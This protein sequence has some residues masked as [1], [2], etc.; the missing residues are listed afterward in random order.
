MSVSKA[1]RAALLLLA[2]VAL[3]ACVPT[4]QRAARPSADFQGPRFEVA[5]ERFVSFDGAELGLS[6]WLPPAEQE[7]TT[8][9]VALHVPV[10]VTIGVSAPRQLSVAELFASAA[11]SA[12][13]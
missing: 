12:A 1:L 8:V 11:A 2:G 10:V 7:T 9:I 13:P 3:G 5:T 6:T 4:V